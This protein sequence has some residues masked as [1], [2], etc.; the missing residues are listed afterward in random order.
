MVGQFLEQSLWCAV[1]LADSQR[2][3]GHL[4]EI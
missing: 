1:M 4:S 2:A 3:R